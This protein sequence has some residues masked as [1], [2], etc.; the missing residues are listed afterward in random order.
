VIFSCKNDS[1]KRGEGVPHF[2]RNEG[3]PPLNYDLLQNYD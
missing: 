3:I 1:D 2:G